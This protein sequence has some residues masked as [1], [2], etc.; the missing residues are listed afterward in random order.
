MWPSEAR[1]PGTDQNFF[2]NAG[3]G[4]LIKENGSEKLTG[5]AVNGFSP[6]SYLKQP[7]LKED[8]A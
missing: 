5:T 3:S 8:S 2:G 4:S 6:S 1:D 7:D